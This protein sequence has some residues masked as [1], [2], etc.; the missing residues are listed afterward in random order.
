MPRSGRRRSTPF[1]R[2]LRIEPLETRRLL[3]ATLGDLVWLDLNANGQQDPGE[4]GVDGV[5]VSLHAAGSSAVL[6]ATTTANG[7]A[8]AFGGVNDGQYVAEFTLP[9]GHSFTHRDLGDDA[10]DSDVNPVDGCT[11]AF[12]IG[13]TDE[14][15]IDAGLL[16]DFTVTV[17]SAAIRSDP[18]APARG[19]LD[20]VIDVPGAMAQPI[21]GYS[22]FV[23][24]SPANAGVVLVDAVE[25]PDSL[26]PGQEPGFFGTADPRI[27]L[28]SDFLL[29]VPEVTL[30]DGAGLFRLIFDVAA[31]VSGS[32]DVEFD[33]L[34]FNDGQVRTVNNF[35]TVAGSI[36]VSG[37]LEPPEISI[38]PAAGFEGDAG[39]T[40]FEFPVTVTGTVLAPVTVRVDTMA[41]TAQDETGDGDYQAVAGHVLT[42]TEPGTQHVT[43]EVNGDTR[44]EP[45]E[46]FAVLLSNATG[47]AVITNGF[48]TGA[49]LNDDAD[50]GA[51]IAGR[52]V[53]YN[54]SAFDGRSPDADAADD[55]AVAPDKTPLMPGETATFANYTSY[56]RGI[57]GLMIDVAG[58][59]DDATP[60]AADF[61][62]RVGNDNTP[63]A[64]AA[65]PAPTSIS[66][67][68]GAGDG[69][70]DRVTL[71]WED[72][73]IEQQWL[74][75][76]VLPGE[77]T[78][79]TSAD[80][81]YFGNAI[82]E[83]GD[84]TVNTFVNA[85]DQIAARNNPHFFF[86]PAPLDDPYDYNRDKN[87]NA[88]DQILARNHPA[89]FFNAL[90]LITVPQADEAE[91]APA[92]VRA[93]AIWAWLDGSE[94]SGAE[95]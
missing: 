65:A 45:D 64:W 48:G 47:G 13:G 51:T 44:V 33:F 70:S 50:Q 88:T 25:A 66:A 68:R 90:K 59:P 46:I 91:A 37:T 34:R 87:V 58:L 77:N 24:V 32:F 21:A 82:G 4:P 1:Q 72:N 18:V 85:T 69:G 19:S 20:V 41:G 83:G 78:G 10:S 39:T 30:T 92:D 38:G 14:P 16:E 71:L 43:V 81:F 73:A 27:K 95:S 15:T 53:F 35:E 86:D 79:L 61:E 62:F 2:R 40:A 28:V 67:R 55:G 93:A 74:Q 52:H 6:D 26:M 29:D 3:T 80:V 12:T 49:I 42:F 94:P 84:S 8:Y 54:N 36:E 75:V 89:F 76:T 5:D 31:D 57:N 7:G 60:T 63:D 22:A 11:E 17:G 9:S 56:D 23:R